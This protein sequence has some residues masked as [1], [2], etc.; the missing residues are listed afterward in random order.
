MVAKFHKVD[1]RIS[2]TIEQHDM[3]NDIV[4]LM[5]NEN[6]H[7]GS[8]AVG[9]YFP[10]DNRSSCSVITR[11]GHREHRL[12][13]ET[14]EKIASATLR[15]V[16]VIAGIHLDDIT[17]PEIERVLEICDNLTE[18]LIQRMGSLFRTQ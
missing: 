10:S 6:A 12:A 3:G 9:E 18:A 2:I 17:H 11:A 1:G 14:A 15:P 8:V 7:I 4:I 5:Y 13:A 16:T